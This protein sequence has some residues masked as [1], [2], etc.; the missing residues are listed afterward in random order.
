[1]KKFIYVLL[2]AFSSALVVSSCTE[3]EVAPTSDT[4]NGG[5]ET[6]GGKI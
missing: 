1:M 2:I 6:I 4:D 5:A 3:E